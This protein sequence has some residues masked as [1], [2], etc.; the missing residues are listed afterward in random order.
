MII[1]KKHYCI[2][3][4]CN[5]NKVLKEYYV[6]AIDFYF[7]RKKALNYFKTKVVPYVKKYRDKN[8]NY[9]VDSLE[10]NENDNHDDKIEIIEE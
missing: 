6:Y 1:N 5:N 10:L 7:A 2:V 8:F 9:E 4:D 3:I